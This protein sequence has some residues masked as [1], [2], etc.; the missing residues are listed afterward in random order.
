MAYLTG[1]FGV[2]VLTFWGAAVFFGY[3]TTP[4]PSSKVPESVRSSPGGY[5]SWA[6]WHSGTHG[7]K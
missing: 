7:G 6:F 2:V 3:G 5:R 4:T 1:I